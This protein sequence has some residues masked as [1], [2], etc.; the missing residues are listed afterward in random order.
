M[1]WKKPS[2]IIWSH[3]IKNFLL[4]R[5]IARGSCL[6]RGVTSLTTTCQSLCPCVATISSWSLS[7]NR[8]LPS[9]SHR[10][11][12]RSP[13][14]RWS[15]R[16]NWPNPIISK[17]TFVVVELPPSPIRIIM[18]S[19]SDT[20]RKNWSHISSL[21]IL[22]CIAIKINR[23]HGHEIK[24]R[25]HLHN[26]SWLMFLMRQPLFVGRNDFLPCAFHVG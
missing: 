7:S 17:V 26:W 20:L 10:T 14:I 9:N 13:S 5:V 25:H 6:T 2:I 4:W 3:W 24:S 23:K 16:R 8:S 11:S 12:I 1:V 21:Q 22:K 18:S 19:I 15:S